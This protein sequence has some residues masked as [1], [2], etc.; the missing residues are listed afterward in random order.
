MLFHSMAKKSY[1]YNP[2]D[3]WNVFPSSDF[4]KKGSATP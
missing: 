2:G 1:F 3:K 4:S